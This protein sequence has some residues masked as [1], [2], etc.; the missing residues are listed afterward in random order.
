MRHKW[1]A[2]GN[3]KIQKILYTITGRRETD[4]SHKEVTKQNLHPDSET[5]RWQ[6]APKLEK[7]KRSKMVNRSKGCRDSLCTKMEL[8][9]FKKERQ[10]MRIWAHG[11]LSQPTGFLSHPL[12]TAQKHIRHSPFPPY[13]YFRLRPKRTACKGRLSKSARWQERGHG[14]ANMSVNN[15]SI[16]SLNVVPDKRVRPLSFAIHL[17]M[18]YHRA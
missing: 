11:H 12:G 13:L 14:K 7:W 3:A 2:N 16:H 5:G 18:F 10:I 4:K 15:H 9:H 1:A 6:I 8:S 17:L